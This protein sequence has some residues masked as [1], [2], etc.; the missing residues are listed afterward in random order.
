MTTTTNLIVLSDFRQTAVADNITT[1]QLRAMS[2][3]DALDWAGGRFDRLVIVA[4]ARDYYPTWVTHNLDHVMTP[5]QAATLERL[6]AEAG[7]YLSKRCRWLLRLLRKGPGTVE[8]IY[9]MALD[10]VEYS[11]LQRV[12]RG[13]QNDMRRLIDLGLVEVV[14]DEFHA[15]GSG[16][17]S[18]REATPQ[19]TTGEPA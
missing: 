6:V 3:D 19:F 18:P 2:Y 5:Q 8:G 4:R 15:V 16:A 1:D 9:N 10:A 7:P 12:G 17:R 14:G 11:D 13:L